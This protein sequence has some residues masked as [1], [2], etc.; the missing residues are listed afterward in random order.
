MFANV[1]TEKM[2]ITVTSTDVLSHLA[3]LQK[4]ILEF[5]RETKESMLDEQKVEKLSSF[6]DL[7]LPL[8]SVYGDFVSRDD[9]MSP[10]TSKPATAGHFKTSQSEVRFL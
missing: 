5:L 9:L 4:R 2:E 6:S 10:G 3:L 1:I 8:I 7:P